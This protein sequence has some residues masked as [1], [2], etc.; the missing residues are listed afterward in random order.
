MNAPEKGDHR[1]Q[2]RG[3]LYFCFEIIFSFLRNHGVFFP[4]LCVHTAFSTLFC[5]YDRYQPTSVRKF[6]HVTWDDLSG[7]VLCFCTMFTHVYLSTVSRSIPTQV[8]GNNF[9]SI[10][11][12]RYEIKVIIYP[13]VEPANG[14][15]WQT[16]DRIKK[17]QIENRF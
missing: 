11:L 14:L 17:V 9:D 3:A 16:L 1:F 13:E 4:L 10:F 15:I 6:C 7:G 2:S 5:V 8:V 12:Y